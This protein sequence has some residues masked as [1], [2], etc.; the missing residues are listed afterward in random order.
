MDPMPD[1][2]SSPANTPTLL[3]VDDEPGILSALRRLFRPH[4]YRIL[5]ANSGQEGLAILAQEKVELII[6]DMRMPEMD[7]AQ[8]LAQVR[9]RWPD[10]IRI[11]LTGYA[12]I[13]ST[14]AAINEG[15]IWRY[16]AKPWDDNDIVLTVRDALERQRLASENTRLLALTEHQNEALRELNTSLESKVAERTHEL[17]QTMTFLDLANRDLKR[18]FLHVVKMLSAVMDLRSPEIG[19]HS[20]RVADQARAICQQMGMDDTGTQNVVLASLLHDIG[21]LAWPDKLLD[22]PLNAMSAEERALVLKH[23]TVAQNLLMGVEALRDVALL[24][25]HH[26]ER[27]DGQGYPDKL[28]GL[29]IPQG[30]RIITVVNE[31][32]AFQTGTMTSKKLSAPETRA[33]MLENRGKR[34]DPAVVDIFMELLNKGEKVTTEEIPLR[35]AQLRPGMAL[36]R[37]LTH[38]DGY[39]LLPQ[40]HVLDQHLIEQL[41]KVESTDNRPMAVY[42]R[43]ES[44]S[45][46]QEVRHGA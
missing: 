34:Y 40:G 45:T 29:A 26:H 24:I 8:F 20:R 12:D 18:S 37:N 44:L 9:H 6:S 32:D 15:Q 43:K 17:Q 2:E 3:F 41:H 28:T 21:K 46:L 11:L 23:P 39:M 7:G 35:I 30:A 42:V 22:K 38:A 25:R 19:E 5:I 27:Y 4:G 33:F 13:T 1:S 10:I 31:Y 14:I 16:V 36:A